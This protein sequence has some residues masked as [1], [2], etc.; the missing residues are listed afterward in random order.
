[1]GREAELTT[2]LGADHR[3]TL[4][5]IFARPS[6]SN[7]EWRRVVS[8]L[9]AIGTVTEEHNGKLKVTVGDETE[10]LDPPHGKDVD[11]QMLV[12]LRRMLRRAGISP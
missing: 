5:H 2:K 7:V 8:L 10:V 4:E 11:V 9:E 3:D 12:D 1:M 6:S